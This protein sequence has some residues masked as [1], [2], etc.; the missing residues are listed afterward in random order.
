MHDLLR[1]E[2]Q[3]FL[4]IVA[5]SGNEQPVLWIECKVVDASLHVRQRDRSRQDERRRSPCLC[6]ILRGQ[7]NH[8]RGNNSQYRRN[9]VEFSQSASA[10]TWNAVPTP[11]P[12]PPQ[13]PPA[14]APST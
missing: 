8:R 10:P 12:P 4:R 13:S 1:R 7:I 6:A 2:V 9:S 3:Y 14:P 5:E 11:P